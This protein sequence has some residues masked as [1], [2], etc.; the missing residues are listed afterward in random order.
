MFDDVTA[1]IAGRFA[2]PETRRTAGEMLVGLLSTVERKNGWWLAELAGHA[3]P[4]RMQRLLRS[5]V[6][7]HD[8]VG[9]DLRDLV[10]A[11]LGHP[12]AVLVIDETGFLKK[13]TGSVGVQRQY[14][15]TAGRIENSQVGVFV[16]YASPLG[17]ALVDARL[18][19]PASWCADADRCAAAGVPDGTEFMTKPRLALAM[20]ED[21]LGQGVRVGFVT[22]DEVYGADPVLRTALR[23]MSVGY[24]L[25]IARNQPVQAT[26]PRRLRPDDIATGLDD[27]AWERRSCGAGSKGERFY[28]WAWVH[29]HTPADGGVHSL[30]IRRADDGELAFYRCWSPRP[31]PIATLIG[32]AGRRWSI[33]ETFQAAKTHVGLDHYQCRTWTAWHRFILLAMLALAILVIA[34]A[35]Q[36]PDRIDPRHDV[37]ITIT[38]GELRRLAAIT[39]PVRIDPA[40]GLRWS[41]WRRRHQA[42]ARRSHYKRRDT[43][44]TSP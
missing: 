28:D 9:D 13:G 15:G 42:T 1:R 36:Q 4:D 35:D 17:R 37:I 38:I 44:A 3:G 43:A 24:V 23:T 25:A 39:T 2:R 5:A 18:Y 22:G 16:T 21:A 29:D 10:V 40:A 19:L 34:A 8:R 12:D 26:E 31:V 7:D 41:L 14:S 30:L 11:R 33:E 6:W 20:I 27:L 32:V